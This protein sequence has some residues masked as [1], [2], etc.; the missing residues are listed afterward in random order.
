[1]GIGTKTG[2]DRIERKGTDRLKVLHEVEQGHLKQR[3]GAAQLGM[4]ERGFRKLLKR[5]R[6]HGDAAVVHGLRG[7]A[8]EP[9]AERRDGCKGGGYGEAGLPGLRADPGRR[10]PA[11]EDGDRLSRE[12]L[13][14][15]LIRE[16][17]YGKPKRGR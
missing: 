7:P 11:A 3:E 13:R 1:M 8:L 16:G 5:F 12:T 4:S 6:E 10:I 15:L 2:A 17:E 14:Q 9:P